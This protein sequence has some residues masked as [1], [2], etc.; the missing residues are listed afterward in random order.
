MEIRQ[1]KR[2]DNK[3]V[4]TLIKSVFEEYN[5]PKEGTVYSDAATNSLYECFRIENAELWV[6]EDEG[7]IVGCCGV[8]P[9]EGLPEGCA[10][11]VKFYIGKE[12]RGKGLGKKL[13]EASLASA[14]QFG[15]R[16]LYLES[17]PE[18]SNAV[19]WYKKLGFKSLDERLGNSGHS[20][21]NIWM[22]KTL[23]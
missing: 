10:E 9:T 17:L 16:E 12:A 15:Y 14:L 19:S 2:T 8:Y 13:M 5:A 23:V 22:L 6:A 20:S 1:I 4:A 21:C 3:T 11:L 7:K 18:F